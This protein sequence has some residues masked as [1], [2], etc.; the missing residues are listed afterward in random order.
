MV[1]V[2][3]GFGGKIN[4]VVLSVRMNE[5]SYQDLLEGNLWSFV[6]AISGRFWIFQ[7][8]NAYIHTANNT[9]EQFSNNNVQV[10]P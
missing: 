6:E 3:F 7:Y 4:I 1:W 9:W 2:A 5:S 8:G 10:M